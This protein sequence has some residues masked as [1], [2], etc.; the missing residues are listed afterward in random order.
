MASHGRSASTA[1]L[2]D[3]MRAAV[4][5]GPGVLAPAV[6]RAAFGDGDVPAEAA[7]YVDKV[8]RQAYTVTDADVEAL[9]KAGWSDDAIFE[10]TVATALGVALSRRERAR[11]AMGA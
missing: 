5:E 1:E 11:R 2:I 10:L 3:G 6:R 8:R 7:A 4:V 9:Q